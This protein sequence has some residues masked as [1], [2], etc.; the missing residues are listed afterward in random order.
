MKTQT[1]LHTGTRKKFL[2]RSLLVLIACATALV[3]LRPREPRYNGRPLTSWLQQYTEAS[4]PDEWDEAQNAICSIGTE[5][6]LPILLNLVTAKDSAFEKWVSNVTK[7]TGLG[8]FAWRD[9]AQCQYLGESG[10]AALG[11]NAA[12]AVDV[13]A[14]LLNNKETAS[15][16]VGCL[17]KIG[18]PAE[19]ALCQGLTNQDWRLRQL[20]VTALVGVTDS[21]T[22]VSRVKDCLNDSNLTVRIVALHAIGARHDAPDLAIPILKQTLNST[23]DMVSLWS[24]EAIGEFG[25]NGASAFSSLTNLIASGRLA[26]LQAALRALVAVAPTKAGPFLS[27]IV[28]NGDDRDQNIRTSAAN[29]LKLLDP[30]AAANAGIK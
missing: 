18:K 20:S 28:V 26:P 3:V 6:S 15:A 8:R 21:H 9:A 27:N 7:K 19:G 16:A 24:A 23:N 13:L 5:R 1:P 25:T 11:T 2:M 29:A 4:T 22:Y 17:E 10:F 14:K 12:P 30:K